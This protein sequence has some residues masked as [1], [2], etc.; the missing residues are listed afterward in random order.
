MRSSIHLLHVDLNLAKVD[1]E[2]AA[3][4]INADDVG[5]SFV[6]DSHG[7]TYGASLT[8]MDIGHDSDLATLGEFII[9]HSADLLDGL[10][11][12]HFG[13]AKRPPASYK[14]SGQNL[15]DIP[16]AGYEISF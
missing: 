15:S 16:R 11:L 8:G 13:K 5:H 4:D 9:T 3:T 14:A 7:C 2:H 12:D 1:R 6:L 10:I